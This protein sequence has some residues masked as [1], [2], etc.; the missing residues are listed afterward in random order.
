MATFV[1]FWPKRQ[2]FESW[3]LE[4]PEFYSLHTDSSAFISLISQNPRRQ[5]VFDIAESGECQVQLKA[6]TFEYSMPFA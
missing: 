5:S 1:I 6:A 2:E 4:Y 3:F